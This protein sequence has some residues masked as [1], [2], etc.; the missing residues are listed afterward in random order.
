MLM[1]LVW[2]PNSKKHWQEDT[3]SLFSSVPCRSRSY[4][5]T[6]FTK[7]LVTPLCL[8][9]SLSSITTRKRQKLL[10][11]NTTHSGGFPGSSAGKESAYNAGNLGSVPGLGRSSLERKGYSLQYPVLENSMDCMDHGVTKS[12]TQLSEFHFSTHSSQRFSRHGK[13]NT[14]KL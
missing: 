9:Y 5:S 2:G 7:A 14:L 13:R 6:S 1:L 4:N 11:L 10:A 3:A 8:A 12:Q